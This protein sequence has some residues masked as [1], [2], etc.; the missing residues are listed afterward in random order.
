MSDA[1]ASPEDL[2]I[3][4]LAEL[5]PTPD[6][7]AWDAFISL[8][9]DRLG[10][11]DANGLSNAQLAEL[12]GALGATL[13][14]EVGLFLILGV[15]DDEGWWRWADPVSDLAR[16]DAS[17]RAGLL[18]A[19]E[20]DGLWSSAWGL[21]PAEAA[22]RQDAVLGALAG[23]PKLLPIHDRD[24]VPLGI[25]HDETENSANPVLRVEAGRARPVGVD[26]AAW[27]N[28]YFDV[29]LPMWPETAERTFD[30]WSDLT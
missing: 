12:E 30:F 6:E 9:M 17:V 22:G 5:D 4:G 24:A 13:P 1:D 18:D 21:R 11:S 3:K 15:P 14:F 27:L 25:A 10:G 29:P 2:F 20:N 8:A 26:L 16:W 28:E 23:A 19:V 7:D